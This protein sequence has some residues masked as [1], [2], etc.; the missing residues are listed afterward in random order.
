M[1]ECLWG[2][3]N[4]GIQTCLSERRSGIKDKL[5]SLHHLLLFPLIWCFCVWMWPYWQKLINAY[6]L[7]F[8]ATAR[9]SSLFMQINQS[10]KYLNVFRNFKC[11]VFIEFIITRLGI[12]EH[13]VPIVAYS[14]HIEVGV[15]FPCSDC[16]LLTSCKACSWATSS[17]LFMMHQRMET[18]RF[19]YNPYKQAADFKTSWKKWQSRVILLRSKQLDFWRPC[20]LVNTVQQYLAT[21]SLMWY[22]CMCSAV[23]LHWINSVRALQMN[24][25]NIWTWVQYCL[26]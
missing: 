23:S 12:H 5:T 9:N 4:A 19:Y 1:F 3:V 24:S 21:L 7:L 13:N 22:M 8:F 2:P 26:L 17:K 14:L 18:H 25:V 16:A 11:A 15:G 10:T 6:F 20:P